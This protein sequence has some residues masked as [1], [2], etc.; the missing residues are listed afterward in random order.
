MADPASQH[1]ILLANHWA[2]VVSYWLTFGLALASEWSRA[3]APAFWISTALITFC[4]PHVVYAVARRARDPRAA[5]LRNVLVDSALGGVLAAALGFAVLPT[6]ALLV[7]TLTTIFRAG[8]QRLFA[9]ALLADVIGALA[10]GAIYGFDFRPDASPGAVAVSIVLLLGFIFYFAA[11]ARWQGGALRQGKQALEVALEQQRATGEVMRAITT[12]RADLDPVFSTIIKNA[13]RLC[14]GM[15]GAV[16]RYDGEFLHLVAHE[17]YTPRALAAVR[18]EFPLRPTRESVTARAIIDRTVVNVPDMEDDPGFGLHQLSRLIGFRSMLAAPMMRDGAP[19]GVIAVGRREVGAFSLTDVEILKMFSDQ[20]AIALENA[21]LF[22]ELEA[23]NGEVSDALARQ[24]ATSEILRVVT[25][26]RSDVQPVFDA[27]VVRAKRLLDAYTAVLMLLVGDDLHCA[28]FT[29]T[30]ETADAMLKAW[31]PRSLARV[32]HLQ[33]AIL[34]SRALFISDVDSDPDIRPEALALARG[35]GYRS[36]LT[37]PI[38]RDGRSIGAINVTRR[39]PGPFSDHEIAVL[40]NFADQ[41]VIAIENVRLLHEL[42]DKKEQ[43]ERELDSAREI[44]LSMVP[45]EFPEPGSGVPIEIHA[46]LLPARQVGGDLYDF[47]WRD[48]ETLYFVVADVSEKGAPAALFMARTKTSIRLIATGLSGSA[49]GP[50]LPHEII[51]RVNHELCQDNPIQMFVTLFVGLLRPATGELTFCN[52]GHNV[53][54]VVPRDGAVMPLR[55]VSA[56]PVGI[57]PAFT[58]ASTTTSLAEGD[59]LFVFT[60][61]IPESVDATGAFYEDARL[62]ATLRSLAGEAPREVV[63]GVLESVRRF[64]GTAPAA[65]DIAVIALRRTSPSFVELTVTNRP[66]DLERVVQAVDDL[67]AT[68]G[69]P[70]A[71]VADVNVVLDEVLSNII[72]HGYTDE[73]VHEIRVRLAAASESLDVDVEDDGIAFDPTTAPTVPPAGNVR[74]REAGGLGLHFVHHLMDEVRYV[75]SGARNR[76]HLSKSL[77]PRAPAS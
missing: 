45:R 23:R 42:E 61:G 67:G 8:G 36:T 39:Q 73:A 72:R 16:F 62:E 66:G 33:T 41:A 52:A 46:A 7:P 68:H 11:V 29:P 2:R 58:Y 4:W 18:R 24:T 5:E 70:P 19:I 30:S 64:C 77:R 49:G 55:G 53:P 54:Y 43:L 1:A 26:S 57:N 59:C 20:A 22:T 37:V 65:D 31:F 28:A 3:R 9:S 35:R 10:G 40:R 17:N 47:F 56:K 38:V 14:G 34:E 51:A 15:M 60:D 27:I 44:Q 71:I 21:R 32:P 48:P 50:A 76:L 75:R 69:V 63:A 25:Q 6:M 13:V 12:A 74:E